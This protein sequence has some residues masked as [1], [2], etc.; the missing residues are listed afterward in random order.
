MYHLC[1]ESAH[2]LQMLESLQAAP[3]YGWEKADDVSTD[4]QNQCYWFR[5]VGD[6]HPA[7]HLY[8]PVKRED[9]NK[10]AF[11]VMADRREDDN[12]IEKDYLVI[13]RE[14]FGNILSEKLILEED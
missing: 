11:V 8:A 3:P 5:Y 12:I 14:L 4:P 7:C 6:R 13:A 10:M 9:N 2:V 1:G